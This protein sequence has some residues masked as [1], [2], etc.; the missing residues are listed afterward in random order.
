M[1][2]NVIL[3]VHKPIFLNPDHDLPILK[4]RGE[5]AILEKSTC[6]PSSVHQMIFYYFIRVPDVWKASNTQIEVQRANF[7]FT[8]KSTCRPSS[9][10]PRNFELPDSS[11][12]GLKTLKKWFRR[13][14]IIFLFLENVL[15][16]F[17]QTP[18]ALRVHL[19]DI[20]SKNRAPY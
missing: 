17:K 1:N 8:R 20:F 14:F 9:V 13:I 12:A 7:K 18:I 10:H 11:S 6:T 4:A 5:I 16:S 15:V 19:R 3:R 2:Y